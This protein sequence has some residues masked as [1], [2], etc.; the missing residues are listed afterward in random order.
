MIE[1]GVVRSNIG[2][3]GYA[4]EMQAEKGKDNIKGQDSTNS[5]K[6]N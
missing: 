6:S 2:Q 3:Q 5:K 1:K 4:R